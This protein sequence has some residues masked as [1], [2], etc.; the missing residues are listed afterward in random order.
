MFENLFLRNILEN[1]AILALIIAIV[2]NIGGYIEALFEA[3]RTG[4]PVK[5]DIT[6]LGETIAIYETFIIALTQVPGIALNTA[7]VLTVIID[8]LRSLKKAIASW[9][10]K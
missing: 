4:V 1:P 9:A 3:R 2:R 6:K 8:V 7:V 10:S 5:Y